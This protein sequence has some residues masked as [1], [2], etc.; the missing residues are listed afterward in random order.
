MYA[1]R[2]EILS[3]LYQIGYIDDAGYKKFKEDEDLGQSITLDREKLMDL[4]NKNFN[5]TAKQDLLTSIEKTHYF[6][7]SGSSGGNRKKYRKRSSKRRKSSKRR[8]S[9]KRK[10]KRRSKRRRTRRK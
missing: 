2:N 7:L 3:N 4:V 8:F 9:K 10:S 1:T 5:E 6:D